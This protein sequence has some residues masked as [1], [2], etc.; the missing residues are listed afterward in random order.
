ME[1]HSKHPFEHTCS[2]TIHKNH[3]GG[4]VEKVCCQNKCHVWAEISFAN[5]KAVNVEMK[6][7]IGH[8]N[9]DVESDRR[10]PCQYDVEKAFLG[11]KGYQYQVIHKNR[12]AKHRRKSISAMLNFEI[13]SKKGEKLSVV[14]FEVGQYIT[15][16]TKFC[17][18]PAAFRYSWARSKLKGGRTKINLIRRK[19]SETSE[20]WLVKIWNFHRIK[21]F[22][23]FEH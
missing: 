2:V 22:H 9:Q 14:T 19:N 7:D 18:L 3:G 10:H 16:K 1:K 5:H 6:S 12:Q 17:K 23:S 20:N 4:E 21:K 11:A 8:C 15:S 13:Q